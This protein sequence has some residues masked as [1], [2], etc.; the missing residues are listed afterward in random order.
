MDAMLLNA[1]QEGWCS[2]VCNEVDKN[3]LLAKSV[4][5]S[6]KQNRPPHIPVG[7]VRCIYFVHEVL[8]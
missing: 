5:C 1:K 2:T 4:E 7:D 8:F 3:L 6:S